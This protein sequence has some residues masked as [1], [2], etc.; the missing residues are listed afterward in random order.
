LNFK[1]LPTVSLLHPYKITVM[2]FQP[3]PEPPH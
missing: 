1:P 2:R 3:C